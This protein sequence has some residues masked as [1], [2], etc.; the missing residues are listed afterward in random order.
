MC[1]K[2]KSAFDVKGKW[3]DRFS[4]R[5]GESSRFRTHFSKIYMRWIAY[6]LHFFSSFQLTFS[7]QCSPMFAEG[8]TLE[9]YIVCIMNVH[10]GSA[11]GHAF[12]PKSEMTFRWSAFSEIF[13]KHQ[14]SNTERRKDRLFLPDTKDSS[15]SVSLTVKAMWPYHCGEVCTLK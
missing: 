3:G 8:C 4:F 7:S 11:M 9:V 2:V 15:L 12:L 14:N 1:R 10:L 13:V 5:D 6:P